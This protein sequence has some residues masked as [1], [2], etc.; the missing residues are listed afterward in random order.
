[1]AVNWSQNLHTFVQNAFSVPIIVH[2]VAS[3]PE[4]AV[5]Y[6]GR[7]YYDT[8]EIEVVAEEGVFVDQETF[9][10]IRIQEYPVVPQQRD[11][12]TIPTNSSG[13]PVGEFEVVKAS[14]NG[15][16]LM[17]L[18]LRKWEVPRP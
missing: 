17:T 5:S 2:P 1:M 9:I 8:R 7:A 15:G 16:G 14:N 18:I 13:E 3:Q 6:P 12:I 11:R 10:D 4:G